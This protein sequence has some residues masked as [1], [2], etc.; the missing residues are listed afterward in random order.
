MKALKLLGQRTL[1]AV[2]GLTTVWLIVVLF[3]GLSAERAEELLDT[4]AFWLASGSPVAFERAMW[5]GAATKD[6]GLSLT[7]LNFQVAHATDIDADAERAHLVRV[8][9]EHGGIGP[10]RYHRPGERL[11]IGAVNRYLSDGLLAVADLSPGSGR[12]SPLEGPVPID[13]PAKFV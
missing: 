2:L 7:G 3:W 12:P 11:S 5:I 1:V 10:V 8:L 6:I 4:V 13:A 9:T